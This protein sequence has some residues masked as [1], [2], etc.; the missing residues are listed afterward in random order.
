MKSIPI[1]CLIG[2]TAS[3]KSAIA[4]K[5]AEILPLEIVNV[6]STLIYQGMDI[7]TA[8][9]TKKDLSV[10]K[11]HLIDI[12]TTTEKYSAAHFAHDAKK[13]CNEIINRER[14]PLLVG[15]TML[16]YRAF[17][18]PL[19]NL[20][21]GNPVLRAY[22]DQEAKKIGWPAL[23]QRLKA[24]DPITAA[25]ISSQDSQRIQ[26]ALEIFELTGKPLSLLIK[27]HST[28]NKE[29]K[30]NILTISLMPNDRAVIHNKI[31]SRFDKMLSEG[32]L[33]EVI[34]LRKNPDLKQDMPSMRSVGYRQAW[35]YLDQKLNMREFCDQT[36]AATRQLC[37]RQL[38]WL[39]QIKSNYILDPL[40]KNPHESLLSLLKKHLT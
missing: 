20:P 16:Y 22:I 39:R 40:E 19:H 9:P 11:H 15:G 2:P 23:H 14:I 18:E 25:K 4:L 34:S 30:V 35:L 29:K 26:R 17:I 37:K 32:F 6:D 31:A 33:E 27:Q 12:I 36:L 1:I 5:L 3:G 38:T 8:K 24:I 21:E 28:E 13:A 7:G 10:V